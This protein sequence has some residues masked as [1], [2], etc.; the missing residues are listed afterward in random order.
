MPIYSHQDLIDGAKREKVIKI[1]HR[2]LGALFM[3]IPAMILGIVLV[4]LLLEDIND[5]KY[6]IEIRPYQE[7]TSPYY[8]Y[9]TLVGQTLPQIWTIK[10][11][12]GR[13]FGIAE[14]VD[15]KPQ[16]APDSMRISLA[17]YK[18]I[19]IDEEIYRVYAWGNE[20]QKRKK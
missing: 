12:N 3:L 9:P 5:G 10:I 7:L 6:T 11:R 8:P 4:A 18:Q 1:K 20:F 13:Q 2:W 14:F 17:E 15:F 19:L 16:G